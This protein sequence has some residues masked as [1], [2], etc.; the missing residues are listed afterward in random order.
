MKIKT[1]LLKLSIALSLLISAV[2]IHDVATEQ[3]TSEAKSYVNYY[4]KY[5]CTWY[6]ANRRA[7]VKRYLPNTWGNAKHWYHHAKRS[8]YRVGRKPAVGAIMQSTAGSYGHV[9]YV[10]RVYKNGSIK[11]S[12]YNFARPNGY[13][14]R[15]LNKHAAKR[16]NY[17]Y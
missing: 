9:A 8:G 12:E 2:T 13:S 7:K 4:T 10:D 6:V 17:I 15:V 5:K 3:H 14:T 1:M 16:M 11:V